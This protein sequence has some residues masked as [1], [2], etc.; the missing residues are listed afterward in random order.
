MIIK[1]IKEGRSKKNKINSKK[2][3]S[4]KIGRKIVSH[5][6]SITSLCGVIV[7]HGCY[8]NSYFKGF[9]YSASF[10]Q[11]TGFLSLLSILHELHPQTQQQ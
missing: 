7:L 11:N 9:V 6:K 2:R 5:G 3:V 10:F 8:T 1:D 4:I